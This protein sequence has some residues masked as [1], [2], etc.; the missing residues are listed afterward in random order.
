MDKF[1]VIKLINI[2]SGERGYL[3]QTPKGISVCT[4]GLDS[5]I[6]QFKTFQDA[7]QFLRDNKVEGRGV[8]AYIRD[9]GD[10][11]KDH[12][13]SLFRATEPMYFV[14]RNDGKKV[15]FDPKNEQYYF[16]SPTVGYC[17]WKTEEDA[18]IFIDGCEIDPKTVTI[19]PIK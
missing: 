9:N 19:K 18:Q 4:K 13:E 10:L 16:D 7:Q 5:S 15:M 11:V 8:S 17:V 6:T 2:R 14:E 12:P 1:Y 3:V